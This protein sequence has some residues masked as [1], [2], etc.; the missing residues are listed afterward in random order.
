MDASLKVQW[1]PGISNRTIFLLQF[2]RKATITCLYF[3]KIKPNHTFISHFASKLRGAETVLYIRVRLTFTRRFHLGAR[4][5]L[6]HSLLTYLFKMTHA[7]T[8]Q[9][10]DLNLHLNWQRGGI[11]MWGRRTP[12]VSSLQGLGDCFNVKV[13]YL[14]FSIALC[15]LVSLTHML[16]VLIFCSMFPFSKLCMVLQKV[17]SPF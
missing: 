2:T 8:F 13:V 3:C 9:I 17:S 7:S 4:L 1:E 16:W 10:S 15:V 5:L 12:T 6:L 11:D 14:I